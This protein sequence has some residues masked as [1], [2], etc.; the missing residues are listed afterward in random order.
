MLNGYPLNA[1]PLNSLL[2]GSGGSDY[3]T[4]PI[5]PPDQLPGPAEPVPE[6]PQYPGFQ[7]IDPPAGY[8]LPWTV[9]VT[10]GGIDVT[11]RLTGTVTVDREESASGIAE[12]ELF[13]PVGQPVPVALHDSEVQI[14]YS[15][16][17]G[18]QVLQAVL[19]TGWVTEPSWNVTSRTMRVLATDMLQSRV[20]A[21]SLAGIDTLTGGQYS[22]D[23]FGEPDNH[24]RY[25]Q[26]RMST[27]TAALDCDVHGDMRVTSWYAKEQPHYLFTAGSTVYQSAD[28]QLAQPD[29]VIGTLELTL[30]YR[31]QRLHRSTETFRWTHPATGGSWGITGFC[32]WRTLSTDM[33]NKDMVLSAVTGTGLVP[34]SADWGPLPATAADPCGNGQPWINRFY[35]DLLQG[36]EVTGVRQWAQSVTETY[37]LTL[38]AATGRSTDRLRHSAAVQTAAGDTWPNL[39]PDETGLATLPDTT[40]GD[41]HDEPRRQQFISTAL[42]RAYVTVIESHRQNRVSWQSPTALVLGI[43]TVHTLRLDDQNLQAQG[44]CVRRLDV[45]DIETGSALTTLSIAVMRG[46]GESSPLT[47]PSRPGAGGISEHTAG[48]MNL[49]SQFGGRFTS[50]AEYDEELDGFSGMYAAVQDQSLPHFPRRLAVTAAEY[51]EALTD[52]LETDR[53]ADY[54]VGVPDDLLEL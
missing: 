42:A 11:D 10:V 35:P 30:Q 40:P 52:G 51:G 50:P 15:T 8:S 1:A 46:G 54:Q 43:D 31:Y 18:G 3:E 36:F 12:F 53:Q 45:L 9:T 26:D 13:Y 33:P 6:H 39:E 7:P 16:Q 47:V 49:P 21:M 20:E 38:K 4:Q 17:L 2:D 27:V 28:V 5:N 37:T 25:A 41:Q 44:K 24:W 23:V 32:Q 48:N 34:V 19:F 29:A 14:T 22:A